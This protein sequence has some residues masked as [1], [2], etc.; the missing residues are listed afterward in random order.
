MTG[1]DVQQPEV[2]SGDRDV[3]SLDRKWPGCG[4]GRPKTWI[5]GLSQLIPG[6]NSQEVVVTRQ[7]VMS[8]DL[9]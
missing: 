1:T 8:H 7:E 6:C 3:T 4:W 5:L 9:K 2:T